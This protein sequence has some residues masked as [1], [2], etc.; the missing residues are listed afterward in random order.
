MR[1]A[2]TTVA[3]AVTQR[4]PRTLRSRPQP[5]DSEAEGEGE[6][7]DEEKEGEADGE[8]G[9]R[10]MTMTMR[11][12]RVRCLAAVVLCDCRVPRMCVPVF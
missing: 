6:G 8:G 7:G 3:A 2:R 4:M 9:R 11:C 1:R 12:E 10:E 5:T